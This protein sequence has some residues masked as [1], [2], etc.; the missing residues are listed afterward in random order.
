MTKPRVVILHQ[1]V[2]PDSSLDEL[3]VLDQV[4]AVTH[5]MA[6]LGFSVATVPFSLN[7]PAVVRQLRRIQPALVFNLVESVAADGRMVALAPTILD[8]LRIPYSGCPAESIHVTSHKPTGKFMLHAADIPTA[9]WL[10]LGQPPIHP[11]AE[12]APCLL[13]AEWEHASVGLEA[14][15]FPMDGVSAMRA[16]LAGRTRESGKE[17]YAEQYV[18]GREFNLSVLAGEVLPCAEIRFRDWLPGKLKIVDYKAKWEE[19]SFEYAHTCRSFDFPDSDQALLAELQSLARRCWEFFGLRGYARVDFRVDDAGRP[20]VLEVNANPCIAPHSGF[21][22]A[23][24]QVGLD[25][26]AMIQRIITDTLGPGPA[27]AEP[28][29]RK[30]GRLRERKPLE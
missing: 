27:P 28:R 8:H 11:P 6:D 1:E 4:A 9:P 13:K 29:S 18:D 19:D 15:I 16:L 10:S 22:A 23:S 30:D 14:Q 7:L 24:E 20:W 25:Y 3:D 26:T 5:A 12:G 2:P 17:Y 21:T